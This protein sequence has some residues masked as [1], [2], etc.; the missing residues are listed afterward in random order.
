MKKISL[1]EN[2]CWQD[3]IFML[4]SAWVLGGSKPSG[5]ILASNLAP[6][7]MPIL[8]IEDAKVRLL[9]AGSRP[10]GRN[11]NEFHARIARHGMH[12]VGEIAQQ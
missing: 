10:I 7:F 8:R 1:P 3:D 2:Y 5:L 11:E 4:C 9:K 12:I 6:E